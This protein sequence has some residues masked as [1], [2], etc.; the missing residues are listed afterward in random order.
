MIQKIVPFV[1]HEIGYRLLER[2]IALSV[3]HHFEIPAVITT[4]KNKDAWWPSVEELCLTANIPLHTYQKNFSIDFLNERPDWFLLLSWK[5][6]LSD[7]F[8]SLPRKGVLNLHY[9]LLPSYRGVYPVNWAIINGENRT[10]F[11]YHFVNKKIDDGEIFM[12]I[13]VPIQLK[14][15]AR[16][17]QLR[18]DDLVFEHADK[19]IER[20]L[21]YNLKSCSIEPLNKA[22]KKS[23]YYSRGKFE[24]ACLI[25]LNE[26][27]NGLDF[28]NLLRGLTFFQDS[29]NAYIIDSKTGKKFFISLS[30]REE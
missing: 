13:E 17:L 9:S 24:K 23:D 15:N 18:L 19:L 25:N 28:F 2:L 21:T 10:G 1:D 30:I 29:K 27:Y 6:I 16:T 20:L 5:H 22:D 11:T 14:D 7:K 12:Q 26:N 8:L 4:S 3:T